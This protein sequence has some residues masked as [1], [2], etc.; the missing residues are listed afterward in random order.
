MSCTERWVDVESLKLKELSPAAD[1]FFSCAQ[2]EALANL[3][4]TGLDDKGLKDTR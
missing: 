4:S 2:S 1:A 3:S